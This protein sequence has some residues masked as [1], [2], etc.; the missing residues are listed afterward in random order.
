MTGVLKA[1][2]D[3]TTDKGE[4]YNDDTS[5]VYNDEEIDL[6]G[7]YTAEKNWAFLLN[8]GISQVIVAVNFVLRLIIIK[9]VQYIGLDTESNQTRRVTNGVFI[10]QF[11]NTAILLLICNASLKEQGFGY[12]INGTIPDFNS[13]WFND[14]GYSLVYAMIYNTFWPVMEFFIFW[15]MRFGYR[16]LDRGICSC[17]EY[18]TKKSTLQ[19][20][21]ELYSGPTFFI[22]YKYSFLLNVIFV[23]FMYGIGLPILFPVAAAAFFV[24]FMVEKLMIYYSYRQPPAYDEKLNTEVLKLMTWAPLFMMAFGYWM[25]SSKQL[26]SNDHLTFTTFANDVKTTDHIWYEVFTAEAYK[27]GPQLPLIL[28]FWILL[29]ATLFRG[30]MWAI[31]GKWFPKQIKIAEWELDEDLDNYFHTLDD[32]DRNWSIKEEENSRSILN[33][34]ILNDYTLNRLKTTQAGVAT[35]KGTHT[36]DILANPLYLDD[37]Q[38]FTAADD[39][40]EKYIIDDDSDEDNDNAQSDLVRMVLN[41]AF[42]TEEQAKNFSFDKGAYSAAVKAAN[43][44]ASINK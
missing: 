15:G 21:I 41:L 26:L 18:K 1:F 27:W 33:M 9:L 5:A 20:Y 14:I 30:E 38:Y 35:M 8:N 37:F 28:M 10:V 34:R 40:R 7:D 36:Y 24:I 29:F 43:A 39:D 16:L 42:M 13:I 32:H 2:C 19:P 6:C 31:L 25:M 4:A 22:H 23:T 3:N 17:N 12:F 44:K 11:F